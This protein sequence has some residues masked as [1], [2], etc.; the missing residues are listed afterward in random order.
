MDKNILLEIG[1]KKGLTNKEYIEKDY[2]QDLFLYNLFRKTNKLVFKGGTALYKIY[3]MPRFSEDLDFT[4]LEKFDVER[5][6]GSVAERMG[7]M[8]SVRK[9]GGSLLMKIG[10]E[11]ILTAYNTLRFDVSLKNKALRNFD[12][13]N[14]VSEY[15]EINPFSLKV[16]KPVEMVAE[17][18]HSILARGKSRD[19]YDLFFLLRL[20]KFD[21]RLVNEKLALFDMK[22]SFS[23]FRKRVNEL[24]SLWERELRAF[25]LTELVDFATVKKFVLERTK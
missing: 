1:R 14:Y 19:L 3:K 6:V 18:I 7:E 21:K 8:K 9:T 17:K 20:S 5:L 24:E 4:L 12:V 11:G 23:N 13:K 22:F 2:F 10:F 25:V 15:M 16:L